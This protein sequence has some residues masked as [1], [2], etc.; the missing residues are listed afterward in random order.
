MASLHSLHSLSGQQSDT[1]PQNIPQVFSLIPTVPETECPAV[2]PLLSLRPV[3]LLL[4]MPEK[5]LEDTQ[6]LVPAV[7]GVCFPDCWKWPFHAHGLACL[8]QPLLHQT[9]TLISNVTSVLF[10][11]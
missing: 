8:L 1:K 5:Q 3:T 10:T 9:V 4:P 7:P 2:G 11:G 6:A